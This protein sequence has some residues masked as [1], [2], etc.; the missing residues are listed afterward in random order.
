VALWADASA[1]LPALP[2]DFWTRTFPAGSTTCGPLN[3]GSGWH[4][5]DAR[6][7][8]RVIPVVN[9]ALPEVAAFDWQVPTTLAD[10]SC[11]L[12]VMDSPDDPLEAV[13]R[14]TNET[15]PWVFVPNSRHIAQRN[16]H[17]ITVS[18]PQQAQPHMIV[19]NVPN[20]HPTR[21]T[22]ELQVS[23]GTL[24][25]GGTVGLVLPKDAVTTRGLKS[26]PAK[27]SDNHKTLATKWQ[28]DHSTVHQLHE[29]EGHI[30]KLPVPAGTTGKIG[31]LFQR[32]PNA[33]AG[34]AAHVTI[35][36]RDGDTILGGSTFILRTPAVGR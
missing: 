19:V 30:K 12:V 20:P 1:G 15:R 17:V 35:V 11:M 7:P 18:N 5:V 33:A 10:H 3:P 9:P 14:T 26:G 34:S 24:R 25:A 16:L 21:H 28:L 22:V 2:R 29:R 31:I 27:L 6:N 4:F 32:S 13:L 23:R 36:T 8:C